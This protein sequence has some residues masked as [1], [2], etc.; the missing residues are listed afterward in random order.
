MGR[1]RRGARA[2]ETAPCAAPALYRRTTDDDRLQGTQAVHRAR[3]MAVCVRHTI[4]QQATKGEVSSYCMGDIT[5]DSFDGAA[6]ILH[7]DKTLV[8]QPVQT[9]SGAAEHLYA[10]MNWRTD[11][12]NNGRLLRIL[13]IGKR[14]THGEEGDEVFDRKTIAACRRHGHQIDLFHPDPV[15]RAAEVSK[16]ALGW[17]Y[18]RSRFATS[19]N[20]RAVRDLAGEYDVIICSWEPFDWLVTGLCSPTILIA[21]NL[22]SQ[23]L[24]Q[25]YPGNPLAALASARVRAWERRCYRAANFAAIACLSRHDHAYLKSIGAPQPL[26]LPP[27][28]PPSLRLEPNATVRAEIVVSGTYDWSPKRRD[29]I[30]FARDYADGDKPLPVRADALPSEAAGLLQPTALPSEAENRNA[31][32][33][34]LISDRFEAGHK[35]KTTAYIANNQIVLSFAA[36]EFDFAHIPDHDLFI[37][38]V[39]SAADVVEHIKG[40]LEM[41]ASVLRERFTRFQSGKDTALPA[42]IADHREASRRAWIR[43]MRSLFASN[44][45]DECVC[46]P[47]QIRQPTA[48]SVALAPSMNEKSAAQPP[49]LLAN[50]AG[51]HF[52]VLTPGKVLDWLLP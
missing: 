3:G 25:I 38:R 30:L 20:M 28:M 52:S 14:P 11:R 49:L 10:V 21:H 27:G 13:W 45:R 23:A 4:H 42:D 37:R 9:P 19:K 32:R 43:C 6:G 41:P 51:R 22:S 18:Q 44:E 16:L 12:G 47:A 17:P 15:G 1:G 24:L 2:K 7:S 33:F 26:L 34:G 35:L 8:V 29:L 46:H 39:A 48:Q 5:V 40:M 31:I 50:G 36:V